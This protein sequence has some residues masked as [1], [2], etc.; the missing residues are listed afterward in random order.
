MIV[1]ENFVSLSEQACVFLSRFF[2]LLFFL[3]FSI[4]VCT[5][6]KCYVKTSRFR[7]AYRIDFLNLLQ[8]MKIQ[9][10]VL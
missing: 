8:K 2:R 6:F 10:I 1:L 3:F 7:Y 5:N 4:F 9:S